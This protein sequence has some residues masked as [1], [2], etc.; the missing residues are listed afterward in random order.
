MKDR[1]ESDLLRP[2]FAFCSLTFRRKGEAEASQRCS[3]GDATETLLA[4]DKFLAGMVG[5]EQDNLDETFLAKSGLNGYRCRSGF[6]QPIL[7]EL[8]F[9][10]LHEGLLGHLRGHRGGVGLRLRGFGDGSLL[11][12]RGLGNGVGIHGR[13]GVGGLYGGEGRR[14]GDIEERLR[15]KVRLSILLH[16]SHRC[17]GGGRVNKHVV[18]A[19]HKPIDIDVG[20][21]LHNLHD[22]VET[23]LI[24]A[25]HDVGEA[26]GRDAELGGELA[27]RDIFVP[28]NLVDSFYHGAKMFLFRVGKKC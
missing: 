15:E 13:F 17:R 27:G 8:R 10:R 4:R 7:V 18:G 9:R 26:A 23:G 11:H 20:P 25:I 28:H 19:E 24:A 6:V 1:A 5:I 12:L 22:K 2:F 21:P 14:L 16:D 3:R